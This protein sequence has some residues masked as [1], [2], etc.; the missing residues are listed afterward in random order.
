ML[1]HASARPTAR[2]EEIAPWVAKHSQMRTLRGVTVAALLAGGVW[3]AAPVHGVEQ[4]TIV[5]GGEGNRL[6]AYDPATGEKQTVV[7]SAADAESGD[8]TSPSEPRDLNA[9]ICFF[10]GKDGK[11]RFIAGEDTGQG[12]GGTDGQPGWGIFELK[13]KKVGNL[14]AVQVGKL[15]PTFQTSDNDDE[16]QPYESNPENYGCGLLSD[17]RVV[18]SD[19]GN[20]YPF[21]P[22]NGQLIVW[23][24]DPEVGFDSFD[25][26]Y[27]K[28]D[29][30]IPTSGGIHVDEQ[31]RV[32]VASNRPSAPVPDRLGG[33]YR[34]SGDFPTSPADCEEKAAAINREA[35]I[36]A[37]PGIE[38][39]T[40]SA[41]AASG[42]GTYY[43][44]SVF[45]GRIAEYDADGAFIR[46]IMQASPG[47]P[48]YDTGTPYGIGVGPDGTLYYADL[49]VVVGPPPGPGNQNG[50][51]RRIRFVDGEP[52][53]PEK[54]DDELAFPDG[55]GVFVVEAGKS[56]DAP[57]AG[58]RAEVKGVQVAGDGALLPA[59]GGAGFGLLGALTLALV[60]GV[61]AKLRG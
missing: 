6:N 51:V 52:Q 15:S 35:F 28:I 44:S 26:E 7:H 61:R 31:D 59:T 18:T 12:S 11:T 17:G 53:A 4:A 50:S 38:L 22:S 29:T 36:L 45:D 21:T 3:M 54:L 60:M 24:P 33:I 34:Y 20:Q 27:C 1:A 8:Y 57:R 49:G 13:G 56:E 10:E 46:M 16:R 55:I 41:I 47:T 5:F 32:Y 9:Q 43:V 37:K 23:F 30:E 19:V 42:N 14:S 2:T 39:L 58:A 48:P 40:P 25:V